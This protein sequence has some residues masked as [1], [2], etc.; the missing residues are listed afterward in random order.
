MAL[1]LKDT[2]LLPKTDFP[3]RAGLA[4]R[5]PARLAHW[6]KNGLYQRVIEHRRAAPRF[7]LHDGPPYANGDIHM[8]HALNK[9]LKDIVVRYKTMRG[10]QAPYVPGWD[11]HGLPI[12][13]QIL[14]KIGERIHSMDPLE[15]RRLCQ[16]YAAEWI[17]RQREQFK[18][19]GILGDWEQPYTTMQPGYEAGILKVLLA[20]TRRGLVRKGH[21][22]VHWDPV[23]R[24][25]LA[26]AEIEYHRHRSPSIH[27]AMPLLDPG[28][29][30]ELA[31]I[32]EIAFVIWTT[33]PWTMPANLGI[34]LHPDFTYAAVRTVDGRHYIVA[35]DLVD[36]F[37]TECDLAGAQV[38]A[39]FPATGFDR[40]LARHPVFPD[41]TSL[42]MLGRH[43]TSER[44]TGCVHTAPGHGAD[45][46]NIGRA[47]GLPVFCPVDDKGCYTDEF[48]E[49]AGVNVF[50]ANPRV[51]ELL[52]ARGLLL[53]HTTI[54]HDYP[55]SWRS[56][57]PIIFRATEQWFIELAEGGIREQAL[58]AIDHAVQ[59][60]PEWG[61]ERIRGMV[62]R[63]PEW[64]VSRQRHWGVPI[65]AIRSRKGGGSLL[66]P[67]ILERFIEVVAEQG[68]DA[69][70]AEPLERFIPADFVHPE[71][72]ESDPA[73]FEKEFDILDVW[74]DSG[75]S[76]GAVLEQDPRLG[77]P[78]DLYLEGSDQHRGWFQ[79]ALLT[80]IGARGAAPYRSVLTHG[81]VLDGDGRAMSK[82]L[83]NVISPLTLIND[84]GADIL[85]LW[86]AATDYRGDVAISPEII[87]TNADAYRTIRNT[88]RFQLGNL[89]DFDPAR[90]LV[91]PARLTPLDRWALHQLAELVAAVTAACDTY[92]FHRVF[93]LL[94]RF[95]TVTLSAR[96][97]DVLKDRL[98]TF[99]A[100]DPARRSAQT[101][102]H[103]HL[104]TL[105]RLLAPFIV[106]TA[107]E[108]WSF[109]VAGSEYA[110]PSVHLEDWPDSPAAWS[111]SE[112][113][114]D[115][116]A[117]FRI[118]EQVN[119][120]LEH[121]RTDKIIGKSIEAGLVFS[122]PATDLEFSLLGR[123]SDWLAELFIVSAVELRIDPAATQ[124]SLT[125]APATG[126]RCPRCWRVVP[127]Q[128]AT[129]DSATALCARCAQ[130]IA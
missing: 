22:A 74:F 60:I 87:Q 39:Q 64:C 27:V 118:R 98:Y 108:A 51:V 94:N 37:V 53:G 48:P 119:E 62:E 107:D 36:A 88:I 92:E 8:G 40:C 99:P 71:T 79:S 6:E 116:E 15:L 4:R 9:I 96:Y 46:F 12:E 130:A 56:N 38:V 127:L 43:V 34:S 113:H 72:G 80:A 55:F 7:I 18:R 129:G 120:Q 65:P 86:V 45:D 57:Q 28:S 123:Y 90:H 76:H 17:D 13:Q 67:R 25:A 68:S 11:C 114:A 33:T 95:Y 102:I 14:K 54:E 91:D 125:A 29:H 49:M 78:A 3:M 58:A 69:W 63:R 89:A 5:E 35:A 128:P 117:L 122:G 126:E 23:F 20:L 121:L 85:R 83:G 19:L 81:F 16:A 104:R 32:D 30:P 115:V 84:V 2:L 61:C 70:Y 26:E 101:V 42:I 105:L 59:W 82:S 110:G 66:D 44:G 52:R 75:A 93:H 47:Y 31:G 111:A 1:A 103:H 21:K 109:L 97:H 50:A 77:L 112:V 24:T 41:R 100:D 10:Y 124:L 73:D 106:F